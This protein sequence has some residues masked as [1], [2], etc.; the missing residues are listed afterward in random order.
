VVSNL[1][2]KGH[3]A[4]VLFF[5]TATALSRTL[6]VHF[7]LLAALSLDCRRLTAF[8]LKSF[9]Q[10]LPYLGDS[11]DGDVLETT[12]TRLLSKQDASGK[13]VETGRVIHTDMQVPNTIV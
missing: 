9:R 1:A 5:V 10:A 2:T 7:T 4:D 12:K 13:F 11:I 6:S 3:E 8:V